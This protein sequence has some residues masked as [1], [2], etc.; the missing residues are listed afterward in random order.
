MKRGSFL[1][2]IILALTTLVCCIVLSDKTIAG[3]T[4][5]VNG[6]AAAVTNPAPQTET[7]DTDSENQVNI[8]VPKDIP[9]GTISSGVYVDTVSLADMDYDEAMAAV[10]QYVES[11]KTK[12][13]T[14]VSID[15]KTKVVTAGELGLKWTNPEI[16][17]EA[18]CL[19]KAGNIVARYKEL[20]DLEYSNKVY[21]L[22]VG[23]DSETIKAVV[24]A[25]GESDNIKPVDATI[26]KNGGN[27]DIVPGQTGYVI[28][29]SSS[30]IT[31][32]NQLE[33]NWNKEPVTIELAVDVDEPKGKTED[34]KLVKDLLGTYTTSFKTSGVARSGNVRN[35][36]RLINGTVLYPGDEFSAY[37]AV[38][39]FTEENGYYMAG[40]YLNGMVV[41]SLGGGICQVTSTLYNAILRAE[42]EVTERS[43]HSMIVT[44]VN[45]SSD[46]AISGTSKNFRFVNNLD[47]PVYIEGLTSDDKKITFNV[48]GVETRPSNRE[49]TFE[50]VEISKT[51]PEGEKIIADGAQPVGVIDVQSAHTGYVGEL[52]KV[53][54]VDGVET[55][56]TR[57]NKSTYTMTP[58]TATV[59]TATADPNIA[60]TIQAAIAS[61]SIDYCKNVVSQLKAAAAA[62]V[63]GV[64]SEADIP[65]E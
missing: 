2:T 58:R 56:R 64:P 62:A 19:G 13:I 30:T 60:A 7:E 11:L 33:G 10:N 54:K 48:Y 12:E 20:K 36:T 40:S 55:E 8:T 46:A 45:L 27:F 61:G 3:I 59:G 32:M 49:V 65:V 15:Q 18:V 24:E 29:V 21:D 6:G 28:N 39:P 14:L 22:E 57:M 16:I 51:E 53:V 52:W 50:S 44:Y 34:L 23:F 47:Y 5:N 37:D 63:A 31:I 35:G 42:L 9:E 41:E 43:N 1:R 25:Q 17:S 38:N 4:I 26:A